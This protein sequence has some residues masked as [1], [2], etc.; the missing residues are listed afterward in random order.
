[1]NANVESVLKVVASVVVLQKIMQKG[2]L[3]ELYLFVL[4]PLQTA[5]DWIDTPAAQSG[6]SAAIK[7]ADSKHPGSSSA[8][9]RH[10]HICSVMQGWLSL[11]QRVK[12]ALSQCQLPINE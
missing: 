4:D 8:A 11:I 3:N 7:D 6:C 5:D 10:W 9:I 1:M 2:K 12:S